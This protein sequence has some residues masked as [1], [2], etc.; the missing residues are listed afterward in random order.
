MTRAFRPSTTGREVG[1]IVSEGSGVAVDVGVKVGGRVAV[2]LGT[3]VNVSVEGILVEVL[4]DTGEGGGVGLLAAKL[5]ALVVTMIDI[6][7]KGFTF[8]A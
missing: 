8:I 1:L 6:N 4:T 3:A 7:K 5:Q 2:R